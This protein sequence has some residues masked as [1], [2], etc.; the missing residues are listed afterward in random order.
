MLLSISKTSR[1]RY[2]V[3]DMTLQHWARQHGID[4]ADNLV[5]LQYAP[6]LSGISGLTPP[7]HTHCIESQ[8]V[9]Y[10]S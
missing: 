7:P 8:P 1:V 5:K 2:A 3:D 9:Y 6:P 10:S 4:E